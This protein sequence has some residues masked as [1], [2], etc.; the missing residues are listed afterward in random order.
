MNLLHLA[1]ALSVYSFSLTLAVFAQAD[2]KLLGP[3][4][5]CLSLSNNCHHTNVPTVLTPDK[6]MLQPP[7]LTKPPSHKKTK[8]LGRNSKDTSPRV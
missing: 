2:F 3:S 1:R 4:S 8:Q 7:T 6:S 5:S